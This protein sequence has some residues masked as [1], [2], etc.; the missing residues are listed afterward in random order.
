MKDIMAKVPGSS[1]HT[2]PQ[3]ED[4]TNIGHPL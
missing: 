3:T 2:R 4:E 1:E